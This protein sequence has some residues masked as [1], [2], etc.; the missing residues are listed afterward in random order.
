MAEP[1]QY[2]VVIRIEH[3]TDPARSTEVRHFP[4]DRAVLIRYPVIGSVV[5]AHELTNGGPQ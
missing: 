2:V 4:A 5:L 1:L 3:A